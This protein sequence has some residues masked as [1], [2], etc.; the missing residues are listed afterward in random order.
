MVFSACVLIYSFPKAVFCQCERGRREERERS[1][2]RVEE[3]KGGRES[4]WK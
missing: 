4:E 3:R 2:E 1:E